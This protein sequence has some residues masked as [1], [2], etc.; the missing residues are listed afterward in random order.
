MCPGAGAKELANAWTKAPQCQYGLTVV[1]LNDCVKGT[2]YD[3]TDQNEADLKDLVR[4]ADAHCTVRSDLFINHAEFYPRLDP[5]YAVLVPQYR[6]AA[7]EAGARVHDGV[8]ALRSIKL[9]DTMHFAAESTRE[10]VEMYIS[11]VRS[12]LEMQ[13]PRD[14]QQNA[15]ESMAAAPD[16][17]LT[18]EELTEEEPDLLPRRASLQRQCASNCWR[19]S[20]GGTVATK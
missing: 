5:A 9:S 6:C 14:V 2:L 8:L 15:D 19:S 10:V 13:P 16:I 11:A 1:N 20:S 12:M 18:E 4:L 17:L 3:F 7:E